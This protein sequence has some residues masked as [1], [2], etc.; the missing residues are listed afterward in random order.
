M[1]AKEGDTQ[2]VIEQDGPPLGPGRRRV[3]DWMRFSNKKDG[4]FTKVGT[5][6][7]KN[8]T[9]RPA[10]TSYSPSQD[11]SKSNKQRMAERKA[12]RELNEK[13]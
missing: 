3:R 8:S 1:T 10:R 5:K 13:G 2:I 6:G 4:N 9:P 12:M 11:P 7:R